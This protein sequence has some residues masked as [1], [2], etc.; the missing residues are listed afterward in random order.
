MAN[1]TLSRRSKR[2]RYR[3][4][5]TH[6]RSAVIEMRYPGFKN[7]FQMALIKRN[8]EVQ[9]VV[10]ENRVSDSLGDEMHCTEDGRLQWSCWLIF[11][12]ELTRRHDL[13]SWGE[14]RVPGT[15]PTSEY[16]QTV[17]VDS[18]E[19]RSGGPPLVSVV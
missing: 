8:E 11:G 7:E 1:R 4:S 5:K 14:F 12:G 2:C 17:K 16:Q 13:A 19:D 3:R 10:L 15:R 6:V 18:N 9:P